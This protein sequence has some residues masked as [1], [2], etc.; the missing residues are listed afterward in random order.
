[1][2]EKCTTNWFAINRQL[3]ESDFWLSEPFTKAQAWIDLIALARYKS[4]HAYKRSIEIPLERGQLCWSVVNLA[5]R[6]SWSRDKVKRFL[7]ALEAKQQIS[8]H[9]TNVTT[10]ITVVNYEH[11]QPNES[12]D[13]SPNESADKSPENQ[14]T[15]QQPDTKEESNKVKKEKKVNK[16]IKPSVDDLAKYFSERNILANPKLEAETFFDH[17]TS[18]GWKVGGKTPMKDWKSACRNWERRNSSNN[19]PSTE[20]LFK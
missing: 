6:W 9:K 14:Q 19:K 1:M 16:F 2:Q 8:Q 18:N 10:V 17:Y 5:D 13:K 12:A 7:S 4:G 3:T 15:S 11:Y 20:E